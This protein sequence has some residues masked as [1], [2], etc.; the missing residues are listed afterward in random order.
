M[1]HEKKPKLEFWFELPNRKRV[2]RR[3][4]GKTGFSDEYLVENEVAEEFIIEKTNELRKQQ[5]KPLL[6]LRRSE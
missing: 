4:K 3:V 6:Y 5:A 1:S 2:F